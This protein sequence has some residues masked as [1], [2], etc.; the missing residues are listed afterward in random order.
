M[1]KLFIA[2]LLLHTPAVFALSCKQ[3]EIIPLASVHE[4]TEKLSDQF[5]RIDHI[6]VLP[7]KI[8]P[9]SAG[10]LVNTVQVLMC[11]E[12][13]P[14]NPPTL[15]TQPGQACNFDSS[16]ASPMRCQNNVCV[17]PIQEN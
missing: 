5:M 11:G 1:L 17:V 14:Q 16:C 3:S 4:Q 9:E 10:F 13:I 8:T 6:E 15:S 2:A 12:L 7:Q